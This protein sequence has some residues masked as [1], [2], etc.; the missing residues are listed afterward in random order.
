MQYNLQSAATLFVSAYAYSLL[1]SSSVGKRRKE[2]ETIFEAMEGAHFWKSSDRTKGSLACNLHFFESGLPS[3]AKE[4]MKELSWSTIQAICPTIAHEI[5]ECVKVQ[6]R[7]GA[8]KVAK[9]HYLHTIVRDQR[10]CIHSTIVT[11]QIKWSGQFDRLRL[12]FMQVET[13][14]TDG[15]K[16]QPGIVVQWLKKLAK[17]FAGVVDVGTVVEVPTHDAEKMEIVRIKGLW[18]LATG[19]AAQMP[20][21]NE[22]QHAM[23]HAKEGLPSSIPKIRD[24]VRVLLDDQGNKIHVVLLDC[25]VLL[26]W[27]SLATVTMAF[28]LLLKTAKQEFEPLLSSHAVFVVFFRFLV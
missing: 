24:L 20:Q 2:R 10:D 5:T 28:T 19:P 4:A 16:P 27:D 11:V 7:A 26:D 13:D 15:E 6:I 9:Q 22:T 21:T 25:K 23:L 12:Q 8:E 1:K 14:L 3:N 18:G 17:E